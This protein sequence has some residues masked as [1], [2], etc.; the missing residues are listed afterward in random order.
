MN[1]EVWNISGVKDQNKTKMK[2]CCF[3]WLFL[4]VFLE[5]CHLRIRFFFWGGC[6]C[7]SYLWCYISSTIKPTMF[8][9]KYLKNVK[10][11][12]AEQS[13]I[14]SRM[15]TTV[16][17]KLSSGGPFIPSVISTKLYFCL[18]SVSWDSSEWGPFLIHFSTRIFQNNWLL[19]ESCHHEPSLKIC[20]FSEFCGH[21]GILWKDIIMAC[22]ATKMWFY[23]Y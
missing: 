5:R 4:I 1:T 16:F 13:N 23:S 18:E 14:I 8:D 19:V 22:A 12:F 11:S 15:T 10:K 3:T 9:S 21:G 17:I 7:I 6:K 20:Y 2:L